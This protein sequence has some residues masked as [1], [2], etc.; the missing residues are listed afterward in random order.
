MNP[1]KC[2][3]GVFARKLL[4]FLVSARGIEANPA[5]IAAIDQMCPPTTK[6]EVQKL[7]GCMAALSRFIARLGEKGLPF[8]KLLRKHGSFEWTKEANDAFEELKKYLTSTPVLV[9]PRSGETLLIYVAATPQTVSGVLVVER[10]NIQRPVYYVSEVLHGPKERYPQV[11]KLLYGL[12]MSSRKLRHYFQAHKVVVPTGYPLGQVLGNR[13]SSG[14]IA[15]WA[16]ELG[17]FDLHFISRTA[18]KSQAIAEF[19]AEWTNPEPTQGPEYEHHDEWTMYFDGSLMLQGS[20]AGVVLISPTGEHIKYAIQLNFPATNNVA[21]YEGLLAGLRAARSLGIRRLLVKDDSQLVANQ[22]GKEYQCSST[23]MSSY[24]AKV[25]KLEKHF[26][27]F[28]IQ[29]IPRKENF[30]ADQLARMASTRS[31]VPPGVFL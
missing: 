10:N 5:K 15:K 24:L 22:V 7:T 23:K 12:L 16:V 1:E 30:L 27:G 28:Q 17:A 21:E 3:F 13:E 4:G 31:T 19:I 6:K 25:R 26:F 18:I 8:F 14:R 20:G 11:Q 9:S 29:H 2:V